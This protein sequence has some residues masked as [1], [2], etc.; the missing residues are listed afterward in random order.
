MEQIKKHIDGFLGLRPNAEAQ[1]A[2][3][4]RQA[5]EAVADPVAK[6]YTGSVIYDHNN[7]DIVIV[8]TANSLVKAE[9]MAD[10]EVYRIQLNRILRPQ[11]G[12]KPIQEVKFY[13][14]RRTSLEKAEERSLAEEP[15]AVV[16]PLSLSAEEEGY[17]REK[18]S[19]VQSEELKQSLFKAMKSNMEWK[20]GKEA[21]KTP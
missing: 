19:R 16:K 6:R 9:L 20:K 12:E 18:V 10:K 1:A 2:S 7:P 11:E 4:L 15:S 3:R 14:S 13:V 5:W 21:S 8:Y 17:A